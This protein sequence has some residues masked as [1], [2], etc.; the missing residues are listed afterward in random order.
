LSRA[1]NSCSVFAGRPGFASRK[2]GLLATIDTG[3]NHLGFRNIVRV[4]AN[5]DA[6][7]RA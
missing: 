6:T 4:S 1:I 3:T 7:Y 5:G 2:N